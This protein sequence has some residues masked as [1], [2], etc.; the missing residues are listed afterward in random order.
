MQADA[1]GRAIAE[2]VA[3][4][5]EPICVVATVGTTATTAIDPV[6]AIS[7]VCRAH[8]LW[9][10]VDGAYGGMAAIVPEHRGVLDG[11]EFADSIVVNPHKWLFTPIDCSAFFVQDPA[12]LRRAFSLVPEYLATPESGVTNYM[13][14]GFQLGRRFRALKLWMV[15]RTFGWDGLA[16]RLRHHSHHIGLAQEFG[17]WVDASPDFVRVAP[18]PLSVV[19]LAFRPIGV[20]DDVEVD[21]LNAALLESV[22]A[23]GEVFLSHAEVRGRYAL[24]LAVGH[25]RTEERHVKRAWDLLQEHAGRLWSA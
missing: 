8:G 4:G 14:W 17:A 20:S 22:N 23:T 10:H 16:A 18:T 9:L 11:A 19:C 15:I 25:I 21:R 24:R 5:W 6:P 1:L 3:T 7:E 2:D 12:A 13:D